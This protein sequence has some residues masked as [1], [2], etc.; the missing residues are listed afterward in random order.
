MFRSTFIV[1][2]LI[3]SVTCAEEH[4][5]KEPVEDQEAVESKRVS[6]IYAMLL[7]SLRMLLTIVVSTLQAF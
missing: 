7:F 3:V 6:Q 5:T 2:L 4:V 1:A